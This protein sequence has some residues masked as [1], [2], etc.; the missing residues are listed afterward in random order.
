MNKREY[1][2]WIEDRIKSFS[3]CLPDKSNPAALLS[4]TMQKN[5]T[6]PFCTVYLGNFFVYV[7]LIAEETVIFNTRTMKSAK[8]KCRFEDTF[9]VYDGVAIAWAKYNHEEIPTYDKTVH[10]DTLQNGDVFR[11][12]GMNTV[13]TFIGWLPNKGMVTKG[14]WAAVYADES[15]HLLKTMLDKEVIKIK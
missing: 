8:A 11:K 3:H 2:E 6:L 1:E 5:K 15:Q 12:V 9:S 14:K 7:D 10:R 4:F 13:Y